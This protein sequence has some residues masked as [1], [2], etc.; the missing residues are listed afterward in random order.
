MPVAAAVVGSAVVG[1][2][3]S[4]KASKA[5]ASATSK[6]SDTQLQ[7]QRETNEMQWD[8]YEQ[9][10][11]DQAPWLKAGE[12]A[13]GQLGTGLK[14]GGEFN[15]NFQVSD[16]QKDPGYAFRQSEG[17]K[18]IDNS[19]AARGSSLSGATLK[20]LTK[21]GQDFASN[22]FNNAYNR[23]N[24]DTSN[25]FN[26]IAGVA[27][28][29]QQAVNQVGAYGQ[30]TAGNIAQGNMNTANQVASN[31]IGAGNARASGY[32]GMANAANGAV[33]NY[34]TLSALAGGGRVGGAGL[35]AN[36]TLSGRLPNWGG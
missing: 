21:Y 10:R 3:A 36:Y 14:T 16:F 24:N 4:N 26:R 33:S 9:N 34:M 31:T 15:R 20:A 17:L 6:A 1:A 30:Q 11:K 13:L 23:W 7:A 8:M 32:V 29:G 28:V 25:R 22:E 19:A 18:A 27:G 5:Q 35:G 2:Y 12:T